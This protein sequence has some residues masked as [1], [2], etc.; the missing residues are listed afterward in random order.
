MSN[1]PIGIPTDATANLKI[2]QSGLT[3]NRTTGLM[4]G[5]ATLTNTSTA[6]I[7]GV[8]LLR[9]DALPAGVTLANATGVLN[10][11]PTIILP[12]TSLAPGASLTVATNFQNPN[13]SLVSYAP[14]LL[15]G[16]L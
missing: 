1:S 4:S 10:G 8:L 12:T 2:V 13:R 5:T 7:N 14:K 6:S 3:L 15:A 9:L 11:A 16:K